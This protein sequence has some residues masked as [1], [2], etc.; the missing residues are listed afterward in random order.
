MKIENIFIDDDF[1]LKI[2]D[3]GFSLH[4]NDTKK[5]IGK[6]RQVSGTK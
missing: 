2:G 6:L 3:F 5:G 1:S 4:N